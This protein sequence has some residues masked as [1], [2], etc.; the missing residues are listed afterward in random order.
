MIL[1]ARFLSYTQLFVSLY[2]SYIG[3]AMGWGGAEQAQRMGSSP[4]SR[5]V[6]SYSMPVLHDGEI[7]FAPSLPLGALRNPAP[8]R[9]TLLLVD[10]SV[11]ITFFLIKLILLIK[12]YLKLQINSSYQ[13]KLIFN[14]N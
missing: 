12:I 5:I 1:F 3:L 4:R 11:T 10:L 6:L 13:I 8:P 9:K 2:I 14:K 7:F